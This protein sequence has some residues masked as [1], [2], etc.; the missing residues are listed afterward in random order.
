VAE[1]S[2]RPSES[3]SSLRDQ[4][5]ALAGVFQSARLVQQIAQEGHA[6]RLA[7]SCA[8]QSVF[9]R[10]PTSTE[11]VY[12]DVRGV[13]LGLQALTAQLAPGRRG[14]DVHLT[15]YVVAILNHERRLWRRRDLLDR[16]RERL[17]Q[18]NSQARYFSADHPKVMETL[19]G[20]YSE[21]VGT[22]LPRIMVYGAHGHLAD[23]ENVNR[24]RALLLAG[25][26]S[27]ILW[28]QH[29]GRRLALLWRRRSLLREAEDLLLETSAPDP[30]S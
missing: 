18:A 24:V 20:I 22:L 3:S 5:L 21:T 1:S 17:D 9:V 23:P 25:L 26:R 19:A 4:V 6:D 29:G 28:R 27:A 2:P 7:L 14:R 16:I 12:G 10:N 30:G 11:A 8:L 15:R 13:A